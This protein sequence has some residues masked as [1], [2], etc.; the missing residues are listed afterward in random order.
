MVLTLVSHFQA[1]AKIQQLSETIKFFENKDS[2][3]QDKGEL[4]EKEKARREAAEE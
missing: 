3:V 1:N 2:L 4:L